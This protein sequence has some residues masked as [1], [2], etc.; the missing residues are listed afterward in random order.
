MYNHDIYLSGCLAAAASRMS[1]SACQF[2][3]HFHLQNGKSGTRLQS[4]KRHLLFSNHGFAF[5]MFII[6][7]LVCFTYFR[8]YMILFL[9]TRACRQSVFFFRFRII[10]VAASAIGGIDVTDLFV[11]YLYHEK[12]RSRWSPLGRLLNRKPPTYETG[13]LRVRP[14]YSSSSSPFP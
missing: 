14:K 7:C 11:V 3:I 8:A 13:M 5:C 9:P 10:D 1:N 6:Y 2:A 4:R 12:P